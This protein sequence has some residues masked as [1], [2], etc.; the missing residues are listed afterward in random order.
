MSLRRQA[1][2]YLRRHPIIA[3]ALGHGLTLA[4]NRRL[5]TEILFSTGAVSKPISLNPPR[6]PKQGNASDKKLLM[7]PG[8]GKDWIVRTIAREGWSSFEYPMPDLVRLY[9][10][11]SSVFLDVGA[12][13]GFYSLTATHANPKLKTYAFEPFP[14]A[15]ALFKENMR[16]NQYESSIH[17]I[18]DAVSD[19]NGKATLFVPSDHHELLE[20]SASLSQEFKGE[21]NQKQIEVKTITLDT[22]ISQRS[23]NQIDMIKIDV[24][25]IEERVF[26][27]AQNILKNRRPVIFFEVLDRADYAS[28]ESARVN[29]GYISFQLSKS[30]I[31][32]EPKVQFNQDAWNHL[33]IPEEKLDQ[34]KT[35]CGL[36]DVKLQLIQ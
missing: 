26:K 14:I 28:L 16:V 13:S 22:F 33:M 11:E 1:K 18:E 24:E 5:G 6:V 7:L 27:G 17:L 34:L 23:L 35:Y 29:N 32:Q 8:Q 12:N 2:N 9:A 31:I 10:T 25:G 15:A 3:K 19:E 30:T 21:P 36:L 4:G 20:T